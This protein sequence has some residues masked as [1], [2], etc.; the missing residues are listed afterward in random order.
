MTQVGVA[1]LPMSDI[2]ALGRLGRGGRDLS[3]AGIEPGWAVAAALEGDG[4]GLRE[5]S[6]AGERFVEQGEDLGALAGRELV[7]CVALQDADAGEEKVRD[8]AA[9]VGDLPHGL[10]R[11]SG[12]PVCGG[13]TLT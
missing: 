5:F 8:G 10:R 13:L 4:W 11:S 6:P 2:E 9:R 1:L 7:E 3:R 12:F